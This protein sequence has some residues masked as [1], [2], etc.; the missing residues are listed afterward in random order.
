MNEQQIFSLYQPEAFLTL[1]ESKN[2]CFGLLKEQLTFFS[3]VDANLFF[4][5]PENSPHETMKIKIHLESNSRVLDNHHL[6]LAKK[7]KDSIQ[8]H[9][10]FPTSHEMHFTFVDIGSFKKSLNII[11]SMENEFG[12]VWTFISPDFCVKSKFHKETIP[13]PGRIPMTLYRRETKMNSFEREYKRKLS[14]IPPTPP[15]KR[16][17][18]NQVSISTTKESFH[19]TPLKVLQE[20]KSMN[21]VNHSHSK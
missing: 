8:R 1:K 13:I 14:E 18:F 20:E 7:T 3:N 17:K 2:P 21:F 15:T 11:V 4:E 19:Q 12:E 6:E 9:G 16:I 10:T 5:F